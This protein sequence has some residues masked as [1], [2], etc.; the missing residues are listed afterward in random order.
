MHSLVRLNFRKRKIR[1]VEIN[2]TDSDR[3]WRLDHLPQVII[4]NYNNS[5]KC[6]SSQL[7]AM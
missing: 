3:Q 6:F 7:T 1:N 4:H 2:F 5:I